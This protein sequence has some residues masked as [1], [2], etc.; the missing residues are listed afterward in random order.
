MIEYRTTLEG[1]AAADLRGFFA[2]WRKPL[3]P[4]QHYQ[5]LQSCAH[6]VL[7]YDTATQGV[8]GVVNALSDRVNFAFIP[9]LEVLPE[10]QHRGIG[11]E[12]MRRMLDLLA[13]IQCVDLT[14]D[15]D[16]Q[17][18]YERFGMLKSCGMVVRR[19]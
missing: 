19:H 4:E 3:T 17:P 9:M 11:S 14:C 10:Y 6:F 12:L 15:A 5:I 13:G 2:G 18:F 8:V 16:M 7:A 1:L